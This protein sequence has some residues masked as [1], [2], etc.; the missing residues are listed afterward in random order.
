LREDELEAGERYA[1][2]GMFLLP[3]KIDECLP[4]LRER[5]KRNLNNS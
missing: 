2:V 3:S 1:I 5:L 4:V